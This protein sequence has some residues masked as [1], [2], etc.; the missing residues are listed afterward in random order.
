MQGLQK[1]VNV[2]MAK[3]AL[4]IGRENHHLNNLDTKKK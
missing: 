4:T 2:D 1:V 3:G